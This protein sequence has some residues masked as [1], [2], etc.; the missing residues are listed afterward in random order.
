MCSAADADA[1][2]EVGM[3]SSQYHSSQLAFYLR[4]TRTHYLKKLKVGCL[5]GNYES[6]I[7]AFLFL[8]VTTIL[9]SHVWLLLKAYRNEIFPILYA[10]VK[11]LVRVKIST[12]L[13]K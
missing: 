11:I 6:V 10:E 1:T 3:L 4:F 2:C 8:F 5:V 13:I 12:K 7:I 9:C